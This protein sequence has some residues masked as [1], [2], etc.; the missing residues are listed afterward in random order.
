MRHR[1]KGDR[2]PA[3]ANGNPVPPKRVNLGLTWLSRLVSPQQREL[4]PPGASIEAFSATV[5]DG[6]LHVVRVE[7]PAPPGARGP[8]MLRVA[9]TMGAALEMDGLVP[10]GAGRPVTIPELDEVIHA[11]GRGR[12]LALMLDGSGIPT[13]A[14]MF[15]ELVE[16]AGAVVQEP[17]P[18]GP[19]VVS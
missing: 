15:Y 14:P 3:A 9:H 16:I 17:P 6:V 7:M 13:D 2:V 1:R 19:K 12:L 5:A 8:V 11:H 10:T 4:V 18:G